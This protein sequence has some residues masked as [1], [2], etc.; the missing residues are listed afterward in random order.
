MHKFMESERDQQTR[1]GHRL[2]HPGL[3]LEVECGGE[4][5]DNEN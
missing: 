5:H 4:D 3:G 1:Y 2:C